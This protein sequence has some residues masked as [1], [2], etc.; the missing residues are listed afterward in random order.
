MKNVKE[1]YK[2][3]GGVVLSKKTTVK[4][5]GGWRYKK[6]VW[7][8]SKCIHCMLCYTHCPENAITLKNGKRD[9]TNLD[10]CKG[11]GL[12]AKVCPVKCIKMVDEE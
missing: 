3:I 9:K 6:P 12:C 8:K 5:T 7:D 1:D 10:F 2:K 11:C 4:K